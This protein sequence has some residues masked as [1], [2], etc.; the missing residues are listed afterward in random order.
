MEF[1]VPWQLLRVG[2]RKANHSSNRCN[3]CYRRSRL[4][5][6]SLQACLGKCPSFPFAKSWCFY[7]LKGFFAGGYTAHAARHRGTLHDV[8]GWRQ[9]LHQ[10]G[11]LVT[12]ILCMNQIYCDFGSI[13][14]SANQVF[15]FRSLVTDVSWAG[16]ILPCLLACC[17]RRSR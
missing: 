8:P 12:C 16:Y 6:W 14:C 1:H 10:H 3:E 17:H 13:F 7:N 9:R 2:C 15:S 4:R 11:T 5:K